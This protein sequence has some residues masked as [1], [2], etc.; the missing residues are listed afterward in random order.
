M[1]ALKRS[2]LILLIGA[3]TLVAGSVVLGV[4]SSALA[5]DFL[6]NNLIIKQTHLESGQQHQTDMVAKSSDTVSILLRGQPFNAQLQATVSEAGTTV[7]QTSFNG[8]HIGNFQPVEGHAYN[9]VIKNVGTETATVD[10]IVGNVPFLGQGN[11]DKLGNVA[12]TLAGL[13]VGFIGIALLVIGGVVFFVD[14]RAVKKIA[15]T[16]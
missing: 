5:T 1:I 13:G 8:D 9:I 16:N 4:N 2:Y 14:R 10:A 3:G 6:A 15:P 11:S 12:G 7:W